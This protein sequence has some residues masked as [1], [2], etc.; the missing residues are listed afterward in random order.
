LLLLFL[1]LLA[2]PGL[3]QQ[4]DKLRTG[5]L[6]A[7]WNG[8]GTEPSNT[9]V[10]MYMPAMGTVGFQLSG[11]FSATVTFELS[12]DATNFVAIEA[13]NVTTGVRSSTATATG[14]YLIAPPSA[15]YVRARCSAFTSGTI[16]ISAN[17]SLSDSAAGLLTSAVSATGSLPDPQTSGPTTLDAAD[18]AVTFAISHES[19]V[20]W[21]I[22][23]SA[24]WN[25]TLTWEASAN[26]GVSYIT[27]SVINV[28]GGAPRQTFTTANTVGHFI[29]ASA[30]STHIRLRISTYVAGDVVVYGYAHLGQ[31]LVSLANA[32]P[33][34]ASVIGSVSSVG[35][36]AAV[37]DAEANPTLGLI[38]S[39]QM[40]YNGT[41][42]D[43]LRTASG[44]A[45]AATGLL[46]AGNMVWNGTTWDRQKAAPSAAGSGSNT[47]VPIVQMGLWS[48]TA[49]VSPVQATNQLSDAGTGVGIPSAALWA[50]NG[51]NW[52][53][54]RNN[55]D[56]TALTSAAR[57]TT[58]TVNI[59][60]YNGRAIHVV[61][62]VTSA[63]TGSITLSINGVDALSSATYVIL[64]GVAVTTN[65]TNVYK[66]GP[67]LTAAANAVANDYL[68]RSIQIVVTANNANTITYSVGYSL[69]AN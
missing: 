41:T 37:A 2:S 63:G 62:N 54:I 14:I 68:P 17:A 44:D 58:Q 69:M 1:L 31:S 36:A 67:S 20:G 28:N 18:E 66:V 65:S 3:A 9:T 38:R 5:S 7:S 4:S 55:I 52:D 19:T 45:L 33:A 6:T 40:I 39:F 35:T 30:G 34:G 48:T 49:S 50:Y 10:T 11:T 29:G 13:T 23:T 53:R 16:A 59:T 8:T 47:G 61:L 57:T 15:R 43:R 24:A 22:S 56:A 32:L 25:G 60:N 51:T 64:T 42:W 27:T 21:H 46:G 12:V 26:G